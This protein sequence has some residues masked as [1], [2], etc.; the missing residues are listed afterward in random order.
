M[1][2]ARIPPMTM[3]DKRYTRTDD[4][5]VEVLYQWHIDNPDE[6]HISRDLLVEALWQA[7]P[8]RFGLPTRPFY[9]DSHRVMCCLSGKLP[10]YTKGYVRRF[11]GM[12]SLT[13]KGYEYG[14][15]LYFHK[16]RVA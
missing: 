3:V 2:N 9:P 1:P 6:V 8:D 4:Q 11:A 14:K 13:E 5:I 16:R 7:Y 15:K 10:I 12:Y